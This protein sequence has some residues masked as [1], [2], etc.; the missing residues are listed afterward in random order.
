MH[1]LNPNCKIYKEN[2]L[3]QNI[4]IIT[5]NIFTN[6]EY[7]CDKYINDIHFLLILLAKKPNLLIW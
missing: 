7:K 5:E 4:I 1:R 6:K 3:L 2:I